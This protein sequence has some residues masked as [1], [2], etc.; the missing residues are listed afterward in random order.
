MAET[1][2]SDLTGPYRIIPFR[3]ERV[4]TLDW[5]RLAGRH[6]HQIPVLMEVDVTDARAAIRDYRRRMGLG[7]SFT[8]WVVSC[9]A[10]ATAE[11]PRVHAVRQG[12]RRLVVFDEVDVSVV[13]EKLLSGEDDAETL[14]M[15]FVVRSAH[16]K[17]PPEIHDEI[18]RAQAT[19]VEAGSAS[20][21]RA[22]SAW[23]QSVFFRLPAW[24]RDLLYWRWLLRSPTRIKKTMGTVVVTATGM[25]SP[26]VLAWGI[27]AGLHPLSIGVGG[28][29]R[30][31]TP[32]GD[33]EILAL[34]VV[35]DHAV[36]DGGPVGRFAG[37]LHE[38]LTSAEGLEPDPVREPEG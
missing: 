8:A 4:A 12:K 36:T 14:P 26:G 6:R 1:S 37:R 20:L 28:I 33:R 22:P 27:P 24:L 31:S 32:D 3:S 34:T 7:L 29:A 9:V 13:A 38:L 16:R 25:A 2:D 17:P 21:A 30:R 15:P 18:R 23:L 10:R 19:E 35:F 5:L 11:H